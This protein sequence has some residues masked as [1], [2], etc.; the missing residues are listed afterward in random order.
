MWEG[1]PPL[2]PKLDNNSSSRFEE[3]ITETMQPALAFRSSN[4]YD[5]QSSIFGYFDVYSLIFWQNAMT[6]T[7]CFDLWRGQKCTK[8][9]LK[10][11]KVI[12][13]CRIEW[14]PLE[15]SKHLVHPCMGIFFVTMFTCEYVCATHITPLYTFHL[16]FEKI[17]IKNSRFH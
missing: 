9:T 12:Q 5:I 17:S 13:K 7:I 15:A 2:W 11:P 16:K 3:I 14:Y 10:G 6:M 4:T 8:E 1:S